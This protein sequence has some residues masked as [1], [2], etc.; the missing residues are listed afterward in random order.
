MR[1]ALASIACGVVAAAAVPSV[2]AAADKLDRHADAVRS[3]KHVKE[4][5]KGNGARTGRELTP[6]LAELAHKRKDLGSEGR[7]QV[8]S[9]LARPT[10]GVA[11]PYEDGYT[12]G[13]ALPVCGAHFCIHY[14]AT[15]SDA[16]SLTDGGD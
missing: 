5:R 1:R 3:L 9:L 14:V 10:D 2:A 12:V 8:D 13:E 11:D 15:T 6:A 4:L 7:R 16:P